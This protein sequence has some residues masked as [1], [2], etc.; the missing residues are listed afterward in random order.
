[1]EELI[2]RVWDG[3]SPPAAR[4]TIQGY[5]SHLRRALG[6]D[7]IEGRTP[8]YVL[9][10]EP[11]E[12]DVLRFEQLL[13]QARRQLPVE[14]REAAA[15][16]GEALQLWRGSPLSDLAEAPALAGEIARLQ[17]LRLAAVEDLLGARLAVGEHTEALPDLERLTVEYP[18]RERLWA[19][20]ML[21]RYRSGRQ[22]D[23]L[24]GYRRAQE[25]LAEELGIDPSPELQEL[26][27]RI[28]QQDPALQLSGR[29]L[30]GYRLLERVGE[31]AFG[32]VWRALDPGLGREVAV[33]QIHPRLADEASFV[34]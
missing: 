21:A 16:L 18:L 28:L 26:H 29:P 6:A 11:E 15:T 17:E 27:R 31:G 32:A 34:R 33:K 9:R 8:G 19:H 25:L 14:P 24:E 4:N 22:A 13:R 3:E 7:R 1:M 2:D 5:V 20:L 30:R 12:L 10:A 23:A